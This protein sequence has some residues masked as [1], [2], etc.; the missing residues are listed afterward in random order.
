M[1]VLRRPGKEKL[2]GFRTWLMKERHQSKEKV[3]GLS[4]YASEGQEYLTWMDMEDLDDLVAI[5]P[6]ASERDAFQEKVGNWITW[7]IIKVLDFRVCQL[8]LTKS[9]SIFTA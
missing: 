9:Y 2:E 8:L 1:K 4:D 7:I 5:E 3:T 6:P